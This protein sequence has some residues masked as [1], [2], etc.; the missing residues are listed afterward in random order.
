VL[1]LAGELSRWWDEGRVFAA[2]T[3]TEVGGSAP[4]GAGAALAV[5]AGGELAG[6]ISGGCVEGAVYELCREVLD[7]GPGAG[8]VLRHFGRSDGDAFAVGLTCGGGIDVLVQRVDPAVRPEIGMALR[9]AAAGE[10]V[11][12]ARVVAGPSGLPGLALLVRP[13][14]AHEGTLGDPARD[15]AAAAEARALLALGRTG[16]AVAGAGA[17]RCGEPLTLLVESSA[18][19]PR[20]LVYGAT[21]VAAALVRAGGFLGHRV[22]LC[23]ARPAFAAAS[24]F[25]GAAEVVVDWPHRHL[26][27]EAAAGRLDA[28]TAVCVLTHDPKFDVPLLELALR[29]PLGYVGAM[30]SRRTHLDRLTRLREA[31]LTDPD[32]ARLRSPI[33]L[34]LGARTP[35]ETALSIAAEILAHRTG[36]T[37]APLTGGATPIHRDLPPAAG[38]C[39]PPVSASDLTVGAWPP[40]RSR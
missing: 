31:G 40:P 20:M 32:L 22:T 24:R 17:G 16:T 38:P 12:L 5:D 3:V 37:G 11:A 7:G 36:A 30:G 19:P 39:G 9:A 25:P 2:A 35:Q 15:A 21:D 8:P 26:A 28:R 6:G 1:E 34:D 10:P 4:R 29:L 27:A 33:G 23:D 18:P 13:G 14:G